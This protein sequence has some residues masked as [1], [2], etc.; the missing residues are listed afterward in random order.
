MAK[1]EKTANPEVP[2]CFKVWMLLTSALSGLEI[3]AGSSYRGIIC[4]TGA[5]I[6]SSYRGFQKSRVR[7][8]GGEVIELEWGKS[9]GNK[10]RFE[11]SGGS[12]NR[13]FEKSGFHCINHIPDPQ[14]LD[15]LRRRANARN[16]SFRISLRRPIHII[17]TV[18]KTRYYRE[19]IIN[20]FFRLNHESNWHI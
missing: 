2:I 14:F 12:G 18:Y 15:S 20:S 3:F 16:V 19:A 10:V 9:K 8:I 13:E 6:G 11:V 5:K 7:E 4:P 1:T 17:Y